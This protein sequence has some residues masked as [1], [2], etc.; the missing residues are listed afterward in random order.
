MMTP[1]A[2]DKILA[3]F[4]ANWSES[5]KF[6]PEWAKEFARRFK[7]FGDQDMYKL[8]EHLIREY[9]YPPRWASFYKAVKGFQF[10]ATNWRDDPEQAPEPEGTA[11]ARAQPKDFHDRILRAMLD[12]SENKTQR[13]KLVRK[14]AEICA[15]RSVD[16][17]DIIPSRDW[18]WC[19]SIDIDDKR[20]PDDMV[21]EACGRVTEAPAVLAKPEVVDVAVP[22]DDESI[23]F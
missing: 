23:P 17:K 11:V 5:K 14:V 21:N 2:A 3:D 15:E 9:D 10:T 8:A 16:P 7:R 19:S 20:L 13:G 6:T 12:Y 22:V 1:D 4:R 18:K